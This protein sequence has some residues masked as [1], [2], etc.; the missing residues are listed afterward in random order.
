MD[1]VAGKDL[2]AS[3]A[4]DARYSLPDCPDQSNPHIYTAY[5]VRL[6]RG[7][8]DDLATKTDIIS[9]VVNYYRFLVLCEF[10]PGAITTWPSTGLSSQDDAFGAAYLSDTFAARCADLLDKNDGV[11]GPRGTNDESKNFYRFFWFAPCVR[12]MAGSAERVGLWSQAQYV[13]A[14]LFHIWFTKPGDT[15]GM[16]LFWLGFPAMRKFPITSAFIS[17]WS[18]TWT[19]RGYTPKIIFTAYYLTDHPWFAKYARVDWL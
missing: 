4:W 8:A 16:L 3:N 10:V 14:L 17:L 6:I 1:T 5:A 13:I 7:V 15:S 19:R 9:I 18:W 11:Y 12:A 2:I